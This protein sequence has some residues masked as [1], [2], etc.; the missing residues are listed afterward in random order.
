MAK[1]KGSVSDTK[2]LS[3]YDSRKQA[4]RNFLIP[5]KAEPAAK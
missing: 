1:F 5:N 2:K 3:M 4:V